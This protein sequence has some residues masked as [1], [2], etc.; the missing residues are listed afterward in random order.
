MFKKEE[1]NLVTEWDKTFAQQGHI[2]KPLRNHPC[3]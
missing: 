2:C 1:L 3:S